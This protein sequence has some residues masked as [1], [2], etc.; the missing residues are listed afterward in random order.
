MSGEL[1]ASPLHFDSAER[2]PRDAAT[3]ITWRAA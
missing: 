1:I 2:Q 3:P